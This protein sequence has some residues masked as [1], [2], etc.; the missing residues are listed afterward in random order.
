MS[1]MNK[2]VF[3]WRTRPYLWWLEISKQAKLLA[4]PVLGD[5]PIYIE[6]VIESYD[7][8]KEAHCLSVIADMWEQAEEEARDD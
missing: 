2:L 7:C 4:L 5:G 3:L 1:R 8:L 6:S